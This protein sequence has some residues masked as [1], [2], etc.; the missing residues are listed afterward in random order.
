MKKT[1]SNEQNE[2]KIRNPAFSF[3]LCSRNDNYMGNPVGR[4]ETALN[5]LA[6]NVRLLGKEADVEVIVTDW[7]SEAPLKTVL[8]LS[9]TAAQMV[10]FL[11]VPGLIASE[12]QKDS[13]F[14]EVLALNAAAR[15]ASGEYI[16][17]IDQDTLVGEQFLRTFFAWVEGKDAPPFDL[18]TTF[19]FCERREIPFR[20]VSRGPSL[21]AVAR[22]VKYCGRRLIIEKHPPEFFHSP[23]GIMILHQQLWQACGGYD[24]RFLYWGW[25]ET[26]LAYRL[27]ASHAV[28]DLGQAVG[29]DF[30]HLEHYDPKMPRKTP[31][32]MNPRLMP[33]VLAPNRNDWGLAG[34]DLHCVCYGNQPPGA[35]MPATNGEAGLTLEEHFLVSGAV[36]HFHGWKPLRRLLGPLGRP[37]KYLDYL[38]RIG[39]SIRNG[40]IDGTRNPSVKRERRR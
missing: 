29:H 26:D 33:E 20:F 39:K 24:E 6:E 17:R 23:V 27:R 10:K 15:R 4:L 3:I 5:Y 9:R 8:N 28:I 30:Y 19:M 37:H 40:F 34:Y 11:E 31:R 32:K 21:G 36:I 7:G 1:E 22:Y 13:P 18:K 14:A 25:M 38:R 12:V 35:A 16:G 2:L